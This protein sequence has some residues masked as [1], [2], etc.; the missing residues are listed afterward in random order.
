LSPES[1]DS[2]DSSDSA[3][4]STEGEDDRHSSSDDE[5]AR[6]NNSNAEHSAESDVRN[7][8]THS[9]EDT[10]TSKHESRLKRSGFK[11]WALKQLS[12]AKGYVSY[13]DDPSRPD[14]ASQ[15]YHSPPV[16][17]RKI[18]D[19]S[20]GGPP[21]QQ[22]RGP[23][24]EDIQ[25]PATTFAQRLQ[26]PNRPRKPT[27]VY[28]SRPPDIAEARLQLPIVAEEQ[29]IVEAIILN[30]VVIICGETGSGKTT[31]VPQFLY[32]VGFGHPE[33]GMYL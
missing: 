15:A 24:G 12:A 11:D 16:K 33:S 19:V 3:Y 10:Q 17:K 32:E 5:K 25:L 21:E 14:E 23:L 20:A 6:T 2:F 1:D 30:P 26:E 28:V 22:M 9:N 13:P 29:Q 27:A 18:R 7:K 31:Q 4:D 8:T